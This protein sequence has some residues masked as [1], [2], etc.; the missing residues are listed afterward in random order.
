MSLA[1]TAQFIRSSIQLSSHQ[2]HSQ[3]DIPTVSCGRARVL[4]CRGF[5]LRAFR[6]LFVF[7]LNLKLEPF[8]RLEAIG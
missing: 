6:K 1:A 8:I 3:A 5:I 7:Y 4:L 2:F